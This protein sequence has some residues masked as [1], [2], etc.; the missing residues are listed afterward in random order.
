MTDPLDPR[1]LALQREYLSSMPAR[2]DEL[3]SDIYASGE[4]SREAAES[5]RS[6]LHRLVGSG[7]SY[8][9]AE[10]SA[11]AREGERWLAANPKSPDT[12]RLTS[13]VERLA[14]AVRAADTQLAT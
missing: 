4:G 1:L 10:L 2:L 3:R 14:A 5:L 13:L 6:R 7:G 12:E 11:I 8:G 9:F